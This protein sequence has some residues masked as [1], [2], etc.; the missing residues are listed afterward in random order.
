MRAKNK[1][2]SNYGED[3]E[4]AAEDCFIGADNLAG[5]NDFT[6]NHIIGVNNKPNKAYKL[7]K[8]IIFIKFI[9]LFFKR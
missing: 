7:E 2:H 5:G 1:K 4:I 8:P 9:N 3:F 6:M